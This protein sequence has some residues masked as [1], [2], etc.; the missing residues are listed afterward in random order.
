MSRSPY[1]EWFVQN[2]CV[3]SKCTLDKSVLRD[4]L[5]PWSD[6]LWVCYL[7]TFPWTG[8]SDQQC[9]PQMGHG[10]CHGMRLTTS[11]IFGRPS[12]SHHRNFIVSI[13]YV[14]LYRTPVTLLKLLR[15]ELH[16]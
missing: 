15:P 8:A 11:V 1:A 2:Q 14:N 7:T 13:V 10:S 6:D 5:F 16:A 3:Q 9:L 12:M 4:N